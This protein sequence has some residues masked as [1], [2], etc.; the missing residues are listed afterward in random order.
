MTALSKSKTEI[1]NTVMR[2]HIGSGT[3]ARSLSKR[4]KAKNKFWIW[5]DGCNICNESVSLCFILI[6]HGFTRIYLHS[7]RDPYYL[8]QTCGPP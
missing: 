6:C 2:L 3:Q 5:D 1:K 8:A 7:L 4:I